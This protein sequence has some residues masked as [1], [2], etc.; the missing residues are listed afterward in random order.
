MTSTESAE[1]QT[2]GIILFLVLVI[3]LSGLV[4]TLF[5]A[6][7]PF[8]GGGGGHYVE[9]LMWCPAIA[10]FLTLLI[11]RGN[12]STLGL[13]R[14]AP[15]YALI[16]YLIPLAYAAVAYIGVWSFGLGGFP[17]AKGIAELAGR[18]GWH[19]TAPGAFIPPY[20]LLVATTFMLGA[21]SR[22]LGEEIGWRGYLAPRMVARLGFTGGAI[23]SGAIWASWHIPIMVFGNYNSGTPFWFGFTCFASF[24]IASAVILTWVRLN[25]ASVWPCAILH[26]SH[27]VFI[28]TFFT[29]LTAPKGTITAY[30]IDEFGFATPLLVIVIAVY[31]WRRRKEVSAA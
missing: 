9:A 17:S 6:P 22:A 4:Y 24:V 31:F 7:T 25:S 27:N 3:G 14:F 20:F 23:L 1:Q 12:I 18:V 8:A 29:P 15:R 13:S 28:Q 21:V 30:T 2:R 5:F 11:T 19:V 16:G 10:A 26:A